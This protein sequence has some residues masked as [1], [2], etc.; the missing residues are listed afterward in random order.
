MLEFYATAVE[1]LLDQDGLCVLAEGLGLHKLL[2]AFVRLHA[3][4]G[5]GLVLLLGCMDWQKRALLQELAAEAQPPADV[6][7]DMSIAERLTRYAAGGCVFVTTRILVVDL[8]TER[9]P[10]SAITGA[11]PR[12]AAPPL[13]L[14][15]RALVRLPRR[16]RAPRDRH[17]RR[18]VRSATAAKR[19]QRRRFRARLQR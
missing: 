7:A 16:Q 3:E 4:Q 8:L 14:T 5:G 12:R 1:Q 19:R 9:L 15:P 2:A 11:R 17:V 18:S 6:T 13:Q 10:P